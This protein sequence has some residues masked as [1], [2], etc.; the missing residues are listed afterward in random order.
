MTVIAKTRE[1]PKRFIVEVRERAGVSEMVFIP[2]VVCR[3]VTDLD[4]S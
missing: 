2:E 3:E 1:A 4:D